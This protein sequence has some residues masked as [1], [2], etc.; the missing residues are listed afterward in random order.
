M[1]AGVV[2]A[3]LKQAAIERAIELYGEIILAGY[4]KVRGAQG[5]ELWVNRET[6]E[7]LGIG[8]FD[9]PEA[10]KAFR[11]I[12]EQAQT[13]LE[14]YEE[15]SVERQTYELVAS[16]EA[17]T[18]GVVARAMAAF[19]AHDAE[20]LARLSAPEIKA[21]VPGRPPLSGTQAIKEYNQSLFRA[22]PDAQARVEN[23]V[24]RGGS[25]SVEAVF[26][27]THAGP[28][29]TL[30]GEISP[31]GKRVT[32]RFAQFLEIDRG[33]VRS[34]HSYFDQVELMAQLGLAPAQSTTA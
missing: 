30:L 20:E 24:V 33:L 5:G 10:A 29:A 31:T 2:K 7:M 19:N 27:G 8:H 3:R 13:R 14:P 32:A 1:N 26:T 23:L 4:W 17:S 6:G 12:G 28:Y 11:P 25:A 9:T 22:F 15:G 18:A 16:T 34:L 21:H